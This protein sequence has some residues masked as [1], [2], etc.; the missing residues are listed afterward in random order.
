M[1][2]RMVASRLSSASRRVSTCF[3]LTDTAAAAAAAALDDD[4]FAII[5]ASAAAEAA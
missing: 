4:E 2:Y 3:T 5:A 1:P